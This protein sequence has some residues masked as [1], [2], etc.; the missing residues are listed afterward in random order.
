GTRRPAQCQRGQAPEPTE[1][2]GGAYVEILKREQRLLSPSWSQLSEQ[3]ALGGRNGRTASSWKTTQYRPPVG[4]ADPRLPSPSTARPR[5]CSSS[6]NGPSDAGSANAHG[7]AVQI[8]IG[9]VASCTRRTAA[10][11]AGSAPATITVPGTATGL[12]QA[13]TGSGGVPAYPTEP[14]RPSGP[15]LGSRLLG[16]FV[17]QSGT[18]SGERSE[19]SDDRSHIR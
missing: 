1:V 19:A 5:S 9:A 14:S 17:L 6:R 10:S 18:S 16:C 11:S 4:C 3:V 2:R 8:A 13:S 15:L 12:A 7:S